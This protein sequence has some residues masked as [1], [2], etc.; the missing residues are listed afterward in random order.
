[1]NKDLKILLLEDDFQ[2][3]EIIRE[4]LTKTSKS[5]YILQVQSR[6]ADAITATESNHFDIILTD[7]GLPD[8]KGLETLI[9]LYDSCPSTP[10]IVLTGLNDDH[11]GINAVNYGAQDYLIKGDF[12]GQML[13][14]CISYAIERKRAKDELEASEAKYKDISA[15]LM[16]TNNIKELL[17]DI[18]T[19]DLKNNIGGIHGLS[20]ILL[21]RTPEDAIVHRILEASE[22]LTK[23][24]NNAT[25]LARISNED[26]I[27]KMSL[28]LEKII[29]EVIEEYSMLAEDFE[30]DV[31]Y[32]CD[33]IEPIVANPIIA[34]VFKNYISNAIKYANEGGKI[35]IDVESDSD[36]VLVR[37][38]D[39][40]KT[41]PEKDHERIFERRIQL[42]GN[43]SK[44]SGLGLAIVKRI[45]EMHK[46]RVWVEPYKDC[47]NSFC[48]ELPMN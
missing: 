45:A 25:T 22:R 34:E 15:R 46:G 33:I 12:R 2:D 35:I 43:S 38:S 36:K 31:K 42:N 11:T 7:L 1:M 41:I 9:K 13:K 44:G 30:M 40:G 18:I 26:E 47:G 17:L 20:N 28:D 37:I 8:C 27:E 32:N 21:E 19:H 4:M 5:S 10:I 24:I 39:L 14:R 48:L 16:E 23:V 29:S 3:A 6:L